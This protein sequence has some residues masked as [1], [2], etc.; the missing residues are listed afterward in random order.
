MI[1]PIS[2]CPLGATSEKEVSG[3]R[4]P[5]A[6]ASTVCVASLV[7]SLPRW[8]LKSKGGLG[9]FLQSIVKKPSETMPSP[10]SAQDLA[11]SFDRGLWPMPVPFP[12]VFRCGSCAGVDAVW[13]KLVNLEV[14]VLSWLHLGCPNAAPS[15]LRLGRPLTRLQ[16]SVV[17]QLRG[18]CADSNT[19]EFVDAGAMGRAAG[20]FEDF[21]S[22]VAALSRAA[23]SLHDDGKGYFG[24]DGRIVMVVS[25]RMN[26]GQVSLLVRLTRTR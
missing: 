11:E 12:E 24:V 5:G 25:L 6:R 10:T 7:N 15:F 22:V 18:L 13:K 9:G 17:N 1:Q 26:H 21:E 14:V 19:P 20:K 23:Y 4:V 16:W 3:C 8:L 2:A